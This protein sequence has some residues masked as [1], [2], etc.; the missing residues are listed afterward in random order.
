MELE[1]GQSDGSS[2]IPQL[3]VARAPKPWLMC[4][5][6][7]NADAAYIRVLL[8]NAVPVNA[9]AAYFHV[10]LTRAVAFNADAAY[11]RV[12]LTC[13]VAFNADAAYF[14]VLLTCA[15]TVIAD[16]VNFH[17][18]LTCAVAVNADA[19]LR[20]SRKIKFH[21]N[22]HFADISNGADKEVNTG[23]RNLSQRE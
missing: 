7:V 3:R 20:F 14:R 15:V 11:F 23:L 10:L 12:L 17:V 4:A 5:V 6:T 13:A 21:L 19:V 22:P 8:T 2:Q 1:P 9:D 16:A 18:L